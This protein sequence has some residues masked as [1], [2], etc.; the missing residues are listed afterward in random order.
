M[1]P[2][3]IMKHFLLQLSHLSK[4]VVDV[5]VPQAPANAITLIRS[6]GVHRQKWDQD[7]KALRN[8]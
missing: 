4:E 6:V 2:W 8:E 5:Y 3:Q 7:F 1:C